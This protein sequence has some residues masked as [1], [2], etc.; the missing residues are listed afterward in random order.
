MSKNQGGRQSALAKGINLNALRPQAKALRE[1]GFQPSPEAKSRQA[2]GAW[3]VEAIE[4]WKKHGGQNLVKSRPRR[5]AEEKRRLTLIRPT[6]VKTGPG[7]Q[8]E[9]RPRQIRPV[10]P[11]QQRSTR[12]WEDMLLRSWD[13]QHDHATCGCGNPISRD[14]RLVMPVERREY[15]LLPEHSHCGMTRAE[16]KRLGVSTAKHD[17][18]M[19]PGCQVLL[20]N[21]KGMTWPNVEAFFAFS[22]DEQPRRGWR[23]V[24]IQWNI[25]AAATA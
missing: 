1:A 8:Q 4:W 7:E 6:P 15:Q 22:K 24:K 18:P 3:S 25:G 12:E 19:C 2:F 11:R 13:V 21:V 5:T 17:F 10:G 9:K 23:V 14:Y 16:G 20:G